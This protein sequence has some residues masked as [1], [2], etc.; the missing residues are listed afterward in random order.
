MMED[1]RKAWKNPNIDEQLFSLDSPQVSVQVCVQVSV[2]V[3]GNQSIYPQSN[4]TYRTFD[5]E[6]CMH[7][8]EIW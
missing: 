4:I 8:P 3:G 1:A 5:F 6:R 7:V 2:R